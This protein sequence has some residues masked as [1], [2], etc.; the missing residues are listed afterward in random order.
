MP[1]KSSCDHQLSSAVSF[2]NTQEYVSLQTCVADTRPLPR[3][4]AGLAAKANAKKTWRNRIQNPT[5]I[6]SENLIVPLVASIKL[7][8][9]D[10]NGESAA[11]KQ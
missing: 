5:V 4:W 8:G 6:T 3:K 2:V 11:L 1:F 7:D 10:V 9:L